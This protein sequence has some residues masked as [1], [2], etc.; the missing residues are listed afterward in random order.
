MSD[1]APTNLHLTFCQDKINFH[2][3]YSPFMSF[4]WQTNKKFY[5]IFWI[6]S[7]ERLSEPVTFISEHTNITWVG[8]PLSTLLVEGKSDWWCG[9]DK[10]WYLSVEER[11]GGPGNNPPD[12]SELIQEPKTLLGSMF[13]PLPPWR[14]RQRISPVKEKVRETVS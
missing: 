10:I 1:C 14:G 7:Q 13:S 9:Y 3:F 4:Y 12:Y 11:R 6:S 5:W 2:C 8:L